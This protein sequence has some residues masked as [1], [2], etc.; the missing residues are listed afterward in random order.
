M[1]IEEAV[2]ICVTKK[3]AEFEGMATRSEYWWFLLFVIV[4][5]ALVTVAFEPLSGI[6]ALAM[7]VPLLAVGARRLHDIGRSGWLQL[8]FI[9]PV[10]GW[11]IL[12]VFLARVG[13]TPP[14]PT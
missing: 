1:K 6:F 14:T 12:A 9:L 13:K 5:D 10:L 11:I 4:I 8:L 2:E 7:I 3:Y